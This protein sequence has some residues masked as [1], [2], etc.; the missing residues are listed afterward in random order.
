MISISKNEHD[1]KITVSA[2]IIRQWYWDD[3]KSIKDIAELLRVDR[4][5]VHYFMKMND[6]PRRSTGDGKRLQTKVTL[7]QDKLDT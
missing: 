2:D 3:K 6:I 4:S 7:K 1:R 5:S